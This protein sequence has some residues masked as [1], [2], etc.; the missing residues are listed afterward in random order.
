MVY[1]LIYHFMSPDFLYSIYLKAGEGMAPPLMNV[2]FSQPQAAP[3]NDLRTC[4]TN[5]ERPQDEIYHLQGGRGRCYV[6]QIDF[7]STSHANQHLSG[8]KHK[9]CVAARQLSLN[10]PPHA[11]VLSAQNQPVSQALIPGGPISPVTA[12]GQ[13]NTIQLHHN[14]SSPHSGVGENVMFQRS[15]P[16]RGPNGEE[17]ILNG[18]RGTCFVCEV[19]FTSL[20]HAKSHL[21][22]SKHK[23]KCGSPSEARVPNAGGSTEGIAY[24]LDSVGMPSNANGVYMC[25]ACQ[26]P[27]SCLSNAEEHFASTKHKNKVA[28]NEGNISHP[29]ETMMRQD[30]HSSSFDQTCLKTVCDS[31]FVPL[32]TTSLESPV[33]GQ[34]LIRPTSANAVDSNISSTVS[35]R[36]GSH[37]PQVLQPVPMKAIQDTQFSGYTQQPVQYSSDEETVLKGCNTPKNVGISGGNLSA[38]V[39]EISK[40]KHKDVFAPSLAQVQ[41]ATPQS[42]SSEGSGSSITDN[43]QQKVLMRTNQLPAG[44]DVANRYSQEG[45]DQNLGYPIHGVGQNNFFANTETSQQLHQQQP[46]ALTS[47]RPAYYFDSHLGR[48]FCNAC[49]VELTSTQ[50]ADQHLNGQKHKKKMTYWENASQYQRLASPALHQPMA[51]PALHQPM[52]SPALHQP[53]ASPALHQPMASPA[54]HQPMLSPALHQPMAS[55]ALHQSM[56]SPALHQPSASPALHQPSA[57]PALHQP[58]VSPALPQPLASSTPVIHQTHPAAMTSQFSNQ[59]SSPHAVVASPVILQQTPGADSPVQDSP[60]ETCFFNGS[61]GFCV[62]CNIEITSPQHYDQHRLGKPHSRSRQRYLQSQQ[63]ISYPLYCDV[64]KKPFTGQESAQQH[65]T[66]ARHKSKMEIFGSGGREVEKLEDGRMIMR[67]SQIWYI[68]DICECPL[69]TR[70]QFEIHKASPRHKKAVENK[71]N[72]AEMGMLT[73]QSRRSLDGE[74]KASV[75]V[76]IGEN[77]QSTGPAMSLFLFEKE[78]RGRESVLEANLQHLTFKP[79]AVT[80]S[81]MAHEGR[82]QV[83]FITLYL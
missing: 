75:S 79:H 50:L 11:A 9:K 16:K 15:A 10:R 23:K 40:V 72:N 59:R 52:A 61:R 42:I 44:L 65:F 81:T 73:S 78:N 54:L 41:P 64:C 71:T 76:D 3:L 13:E 55:P 68:C 22:G 32:R 80:N 67:D 5:M 27:F 74:Q 35:D 53:M 7:T 4:N 82:V 66:S 17:Y 58:S 47:P 14:V 18:S 28:K 63:G 62:V 56:A 36:E 25:S 83:M 1:V 31:P 77:V 33:L 60:D 51:S 37:V 48:G 29:T 46:Q 12:N 39:A 19:E 26:V 24:H 57:S 8:Q 69:N 21:N 6:C 34:G 43:C 30:S 2:D 49:N 70:E 20:E 45:R 38:N